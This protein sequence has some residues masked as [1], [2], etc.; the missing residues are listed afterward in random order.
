M[1]RHTENAIKVAERLKQDDRVAWVNYAGLP[2][3]P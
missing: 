1:E 2:D 3:S